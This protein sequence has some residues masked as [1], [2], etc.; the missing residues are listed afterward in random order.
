MSK[1]PSNRDPVFGCLLYAGK[2]DRDGYGRHNGRLAHRVAW[3]EVHGPIGVSDKGEP[4]TVEH[5]CRRRACIN[6]KHLE[7]LSRSDQERAKNWRR[8]A[9]RQCPNGCPMDVTAMITPAG[10]RLCRRC[11]R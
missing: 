10:G 4:L 2:L 5:I 8:R 3:E 1:I 7:L 6:P 9:K 11:E